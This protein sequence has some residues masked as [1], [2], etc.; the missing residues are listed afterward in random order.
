[1]N[2]PFV[3]WVPIDAEHGPSYQCIV[4]TW[5]GG[6]WYYDLVRWDQREKPPKYWLDVGYRFYRPI[7]APQEEKKAHD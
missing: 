2:E 1:M 5:H 4:A 7:T 6:G 3:E